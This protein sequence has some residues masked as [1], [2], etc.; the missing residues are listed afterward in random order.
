MNVLDLGQHVDEAGEVVAIERAEVFDAEAFEDLAGPEGVLDAVADHVPGAFDRVAY[1]RGQLVHDPLGKLLGLFVGGADADA[2]EVLGESALRIAD[3]HAV[4]VQN[5]QHLTPQCSGA[6]QALEGQAVHD[7]G[8]AD[9]GNDVVRTADLLVAAGHAD[10]R[11]DRCSSVADGE[12]VI[13]R[14]FGG[15]K[16]A[17]RALLAKLGKLCGSSR[18][19]LMRVALVAHVPEKPVR[20]GGIR[21]KVVDV[22]QRDRQLDHPQVRGQVAAVLRDR[23][24]DHIAHLGRKLAQFRHRELA[25][26]R[27]GT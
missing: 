8:I 19:E 25:A 21:A 15:R 5:D 9:D 23:V 3:A 22:M 18:Q 12:Q 17:H 24:E 4:V 10:R 27:P 11:A 1:R 6:V 14:F 2:F 20:A 7:G 26:N 16:S 13:G